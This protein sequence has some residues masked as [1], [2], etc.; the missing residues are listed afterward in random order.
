MLYVLLGC[1]AFALVAVVTWWIFEDLR[2][3][4]EDPTED[5]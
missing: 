3:A 5:E 2:S 1:G 4:P